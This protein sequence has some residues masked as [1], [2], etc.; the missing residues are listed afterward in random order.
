[1]CDRV[2]CRL[3]QL[4]E[5]S[6]VLS[7]S[8]TGCATDDSSVSDRWI[9]VWLDVRQSHLSTLSGEV[10]HAFIVR[11]M[12]HSMSHSF[13]ESTATHLSHIWKN[14]CVNEY[15]LHIITWM[16]QCVAV[17][18]SAMS[19]LPHIC[20]TSE[21]T[22]VW[23]SHLLHIMTYRCVNEMCKSH[24]YLSCEWVVCRT[25]SEWVVCFHMNE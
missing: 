18:C 24:M 13:N 21:K 15:L 9:D 4:H 7:L 16:S 14:T 10:T 1:M 6:Q 12:T 11:Q 20:H 2:I 22:H 23:M 5:R 8:L 19:H 17:C 3:I 25:S